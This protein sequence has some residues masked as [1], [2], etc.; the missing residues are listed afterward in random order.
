MYEVYFA[1]LSKRVSL[2]D[3]ERDFI[4]SHLSLKK[5]RRRQYLLQ[6]EELCRYIC[7]VE[8]GMLRS[9]TVDSQGNEHIMQFAPEGWFISDLYSFLTDEPSSYNIDALEE[10]ELVLI[11]R[12]AHQQLLEKSPKYLTF[13]HML[14]T[15]A[16]IAMQKRLNAINDQTS[17]ERYTR[18]I[19]KFPEIT[20]RVP[21]HMIASYLGLTPETLS[22]VRKR[23]ATAAKH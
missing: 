16:Y 5:I 22:R 13:S 18:F 7:F 19:Q 12:S 2:T 15:N 9:Y 4:Q 10:S 3:Q 20:N 6:D 17:E 1:E 8:K 11:S 14:I 21:Q 23:I